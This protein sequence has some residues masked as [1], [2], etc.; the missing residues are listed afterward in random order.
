MLP[1]KAK[2][3]KIFTGFTKMGETPPKDQ[4]TLMKITPLNSAYQKTIL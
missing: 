1:I 2:S 4:V 3:L